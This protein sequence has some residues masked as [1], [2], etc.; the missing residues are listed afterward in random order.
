MQKITSLGISGL[1]KDLEKERKQK[2]YFNTIG[3]GEKE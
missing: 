2:N 1:L 3:K